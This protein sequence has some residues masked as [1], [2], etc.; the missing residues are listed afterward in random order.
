MLSSIQNEP[1]LL[2]GTRLL[3]VDDEES[4]LKSL[5]RLTR[6]M[7]IECEFASSGAE[8]LK[9]FDEDPF[10]IVISDMRMPEMDGAMFLAQVAQKYPESIRIVLTGY[11]EENLV[12]SAIN[13]GRI[14][15]YISKPWDETSLIT[16]L[17]QAIATQQMVAERAL[18]RHTVERY[19][20]EHK[21]RFMGFVGS[22]IA[23]NF[24]YNVIERAAASQASVFITGPSGTGKE[25]C[26]EAIHKL[27]HRASGP[28]IA[29]NCA[30][31]P[32]ELME[33]EIFGH[34]KGAFSGAVSNREGA[35]SAANGGTLFLDE[36]GEM[37]INLQAKLLRF[38]Q[39]STVQK[40]GGNKTEKVDIRFVCATNRLPLDAIDSGKLREDLYYRLNVIAVDMPSLCDRDRDPIILAQHFIDK[41]SE[42]ENKVFSG[43]SSKAESLLLAYSWPGNVRQ[44]ENAIHN[45][46]VMGSGPLITDELLAMSLRLSK[47]DVEA[48]IGKDNEDS[49][50]DDRSRGGLSSREA[51]DCTDEN[52]IAKDSEIRSLHEI[53]RNYVERA[54]DI[55]DGN[56]VS[57]ASSLG[58]SP[59]TLYRKIQSWK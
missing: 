1:P 11:S 58:V 4:I 15:G 13:E 38:I 3:F 26:A 45:T 33:S 57:A 35:A 18:L 55:C 40:V 43:L 46:V 24:V 32:S 50:M 34:V 27:S 8:G 41:F 59:S 48:S 21:Q 54:I 20:R 49:Y 37:D 31:I 44:L 29:L 7:N 9:L 39:T 5:K 16:T 25:I 6:G 56:V 14:W 52:S 30:A 17:Q 22:S 28:F 2:Q 36:L 47:S 42:K 12:L 10:D 19:T 51:T 53:E 23:M